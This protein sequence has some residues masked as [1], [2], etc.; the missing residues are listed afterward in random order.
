MALLGYGGIGVFNSR[1]VVFDG[2]G[3]HEF[4]EGQTD[5]PIRARLSTHV[6]AWEALDA[7][8][9]SEESTRFLGAVI[10]GGG[11][12]LADWIGN[13]FPGT[14]VAPIAQDWLRLWGL[15]LKRF[16]E[17]RELRNEMSYR[18]S[19][20]TAVSM[21]EVGATV[22]VL[23][24]AWN[25]FEPYE[26]GDFA[27]L[28]RFLI[29][30]AIERTFQ[31]ITERSPKQSKKR[32]HVVVQNVVSELNFD[33]MAAEFWISFLQDIDRNDFPDP[34]LLQASRDSWIDKPR[35]V[36]QLL[37]RAA[38]LLRVATGA[39]ERLLANSD[40]KQSEL[41]FWWRP[42]AEGAGLASPGDDLT[43]MSILWGDV[44]GALQDLKAGG[45][46]NDRKSWLTRNAGPL[47][48]LTGFERVGLWG[49]F[50]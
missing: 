47:M 9:L 4:I 38:L 25:I 24:D 35:H 49:L 13:A 23:A 12:T 31:R 37:G 1:H 32:Y 2:L 50:P 17:D 15:D 41:E 10:S 43:S 29:R 33:T 40:L 21:P 28:D 3:K 42:L 20:I 48:T 5:E 26:T 34:I 8:A 6:F 18:P 19:R 36:D 30:S 16:A 45:S 27:N 46:I 11:V 7:W 22:D 14:T 39:T 44:D